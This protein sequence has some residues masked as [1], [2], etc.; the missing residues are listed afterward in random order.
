MA[1]GL[2]ALFQIL[3]V[4][5]FGAPEGLGGLDFG[6]D[7]LW[8]EM[9]RSGELLDLGLGLR[10]LLGS[11][12]EDG[13][14]ILR[15]PVG[16]LTVECGGVVKFEESVEQF[17]IA[18]FFGIEVKLDDFGMAGL[19]GTDVFVG[20]LVELASLITDGGGG[21]AGDRGEGGFDT[22]ETTCSKCRFFDGHIYQMREQFIW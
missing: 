5:L 16:S 6:D 15:A 14:A 3:L 9:A 19:V 11:V 10:F 18:D 20:G 4:V 21:D 22:P 17:L 8:C 7:A 1:A 12:K 2:A 13:G